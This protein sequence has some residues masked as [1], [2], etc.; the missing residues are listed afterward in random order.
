MLVEPPHHWTLCEQP[1]DKPFSKVCCCCLPSPELHPTLH[2]P[3]TWKNFTSV[4]PWFILYFTYIGLAQFTF[5]KPS[6]MSTL[7]TAYLHRSRL[8]IYY[9]RHLESDF[10]TRNYFFLLS[11][12]SIAISLFNSFSSSVILSNISFRQ[13]NVQLINL[14][15]IH[16][17]LL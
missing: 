9:K 15:C 3:L 11:A 17:P 7:L 1:L 13:H 16:I 4:E 8:R 5:P 12:S 2:I 6:E 10:R 14:I